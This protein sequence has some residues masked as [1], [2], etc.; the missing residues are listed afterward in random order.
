[1]TILWTGPTPSLGKAG[2]DLGW[3][4]ATWPL[5]LTREAENKGLDS[6]IRRLLLDPIYSLYYLQQVFFTGRAGPGRSKNE[7]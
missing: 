5:F 3:P 1:M 7:A 6:T 2:L 4:M